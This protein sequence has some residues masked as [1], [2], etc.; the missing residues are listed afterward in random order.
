MATPVV[1][2]KFNDGTVWLR[3][4]T[5]CIQIFSGY[6]LPGTEKSQPQRNVDRILG[7]KLIEL[8]NSSERWVPTV[9]EL[10]NL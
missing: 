6:P 5:H 10:L 7:R 8:P 2:M 3:N 1:C 9:R 4:F